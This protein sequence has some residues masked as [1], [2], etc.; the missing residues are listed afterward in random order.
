MKL[1]SALVAASI[2]LSGLVPEVVI[3]QPRPPGW[4]H[5][6]WG[7]PGW[8]RGRRWRGRRCHWVWRHHRRVW[9]CW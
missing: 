1:I 2:A 8:R 6:G 3:A 9:V 5:P 7:H 4:H